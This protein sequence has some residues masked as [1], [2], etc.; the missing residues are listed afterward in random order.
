MLRYSFG[1]R[2]TTVM[3]SLCRHADEDQV[4]SDADFLSLG[5]LLGR[6][7]YISS[8]VM[9]KKPDTQIILY[10]MVDVLALTKGLS[11]HLLQ[12]PH[13][14]GLLQH[15]GA[16]TQVWRNILREETEKGETVAH[17]VSESLDGQ[18]ELAMLLQD[19]GHALEH[20]LIV[21]PERERSL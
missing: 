1:T 6:R 9:K 16:N 7:V 8:Q 2:G 5:S 4:V 10:V 17:A 11:Q 15:K 13:R 14:Q 20:H 21:L 12:G 18:A 19:G 3:V